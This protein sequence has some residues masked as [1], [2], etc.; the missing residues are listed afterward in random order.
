[1]KLTKKQIEDLR[2][3]VESVVSGMVDSLIE[4]TSDEYYRGQVMENL[5]DEVF[6]EEEI[7]EVEEMWNNVDKEG[8]I[9]T[10]ILEGFVKEVTDS[11]M[12]KYR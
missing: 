2:S 3:S 1:M 11:I 9:D 8:G 4:E 10:D 12:M 6:S 7:E 5:S